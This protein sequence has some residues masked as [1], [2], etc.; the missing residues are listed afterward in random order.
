MKRFC[1]LLNG[2]VINIGDWDD[3]GGQN[4]IPKGSVK[5]ELEC[6]QNAD[7]SWVAVGYEPI[8]SVSLDVVVEENA[9]LRQENEGLKK[10]MDSAEKSIL[11]LLKI[12]L[13]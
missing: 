5:K 2:K 1:V 11:A 4:P 12:K 13:I 8:A 10:R 7:G 3:L 9:V 6:K